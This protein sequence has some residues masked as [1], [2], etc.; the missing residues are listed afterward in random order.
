V[1]RLTACLLLLLSCWV[2]KG[3][4]KIIGDIREQKISQ[5][6]GIDERE[7]RVY[8]R[9][10]TYLILASKIVRPSTTYQV[11]YIV[12]IKDIVN[13]KVRLKG[14]YLSCCEAEDSKFLYLFCS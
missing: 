3:Q 13:N 1:C 2:G 4:R 12:P 7:E 5:V 6:A 9:P 10:P 8:R 11:Q 14:Y